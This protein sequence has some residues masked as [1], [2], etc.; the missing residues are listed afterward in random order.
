MLQIIT[1]TNKLTQ[2][3]R[4]VSKALSKN[5]QG[6]SATPVKSFSFYI[7]IKFKIIKTLRRSTKRNTQYLSLFISRLYNHTKLFS[8]KILVLILISTDLQYLA[9]KDVWTI[10][11]VLKESSRIRQLSKI[12][13]ALLV[14]S[15]TEW[16]QPMSSW[17]NVVTVSFFKEGSYLTFCC[18]VAFSDGVDNPKNK[19]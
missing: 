17:I 8:L 3:S 4:L 11:I 19:N 13:G 2:V 9:L 5:G 15:R 6:Y 14:S 18:G 7:I 12:A 16:E 10:G 1:I